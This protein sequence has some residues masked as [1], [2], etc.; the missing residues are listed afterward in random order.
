MA[1][2]LLVSL[3]TEKGKSLLKFPE[4]SHREYHVKGK[5]ETIPTKKPKGFR[6][7]THAR[8]IRLVVGS[9]GGLYLDRAP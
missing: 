3:Q 9:Y 5:S 2:L 8:H 1:A 4:C 7:A 6:R